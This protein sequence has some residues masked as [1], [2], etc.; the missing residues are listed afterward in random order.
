MNET[1]HTYNHHLIGWAIYRFQFVTSI[2]S[3]LTTRMSYY[4]Y[5]VTIFSI[6]HSLNVLTFTLYAWATLGSNEKLQYGND[7]ATKKKSSCRMK[8]IFT[9]VGTFI[10][11][12]AVF[13]V[14]KSH[15]CSISESNAHITSHCIMR[16]VDWRPHRFIFLWK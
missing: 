12:I 3:N 6:F 5:S 10:S 7:Y 9:L 14:P 16:L 1:K 8:L 13:D 2:I 4:E 11:K 15:T